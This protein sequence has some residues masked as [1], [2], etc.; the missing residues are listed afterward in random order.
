VSTPLYTAAL[1]AA[2]DRAATE[3]HGIP[4]RRLMELAG[5]AAWNHMLKRWPAAQRIQIFCGSGNNGGDGFVVAC[6]ARQAG[7]E[8]QIVRLGDADKMSGDARYWLQAAADIGL[9]PVA[10]GAAKA[11]EPDLVVDALLGTGLQREVS[12]EWRDAI[13]WMNG[14]DGD[15]ISIDVPSGINADTGAIMGTAVN[16]DATVTFIGRKQGLYSGQAPGCCGEIHFRDLDVPAEIY[17][18]ISASAR[19]LDCDDYADVLRARS[20]TAHKGDFGHAL[21][22]A[23]RPASAPSTE[24]PSPSMTATC[25]PARRPPARPWHSAT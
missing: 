3:E 4:G 18:R 5:T 8:V 21:I 11:F 13:D 6:L 25:S 16:A 2:L 24:T 19:L 9:I 7:R 23:D 10:L 20:R 22:T 14:L 15:R 17:E 12:G 1:V